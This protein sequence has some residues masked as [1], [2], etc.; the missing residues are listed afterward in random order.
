MATMGLA[1]GVSIGFAADQPATETLPKWN[2]IVVE[3]AFRSEG[4]AIADVNKDGKMD[5]LVGDLWYESPNWTKHEIRKVGDYGD[6][7]RKYSECM[8]C[9]TDDLNADGWTDL[10]VIGFPGKPTYWYENPKGAT[11]HW[12]QHEIWHSACNETPQYVD[13]FGTGK[14]VLVMGWQPKGRGNGNEGQMSWFEPDANPKKPWVMHPISESSSPG[15]PI[16]GTMPFSHGLGVGDL[17][18]DGRLDVICTGGWWEQ[19]TEGANATGP[20]P[21]HPANLGPNC[22]DMYTIDLDADGKA[23]VVSS[24]AHQYGIWSYMQKPGSGGHPSFLKQDL[25]PKLTSETHAMHY[26]DI[27]GDGLKDLITGKRKWSHG[28]S[29]PGSDLD[30]ELYWLQAKK[31]KDGLI[32]F[33]PRLIDKD[34]GI[35]TQFVVADFNGDGVPDIVTSNKHGVFVHLQDRQK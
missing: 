5:V 22:A 34:S 20:W 29:E 25:F 11:G 9:F 3:R 18:N 17:N 16:V 4:V 13:L 10:I 35:G 15:K 23:D 19:P 32:S 27:D 33:T 1:L 30:P 7:L 12:P 14:R 24:S 2:K 26:V 21:F 6:G 8:L 31:S 28:K